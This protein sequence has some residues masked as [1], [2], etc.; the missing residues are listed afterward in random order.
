MKLIKPGRLVFMAVFFIALLVLYL[1]TLYRLQIVEGDAYYEQSTNSIQTTET[2]VAAR[3]NILDRY[4]RLLVYNRNC[5]NLLLDTDELFS[6]SNDEA[7]ASILSMCRIVTECGDTYYDTLPVTRTTPFEYTEM[8]QLQ[9]TRLDAFLE[10]AGLD[11]DASAVE[12]MAYMRTRYG[13]DN[14]YSAADMRTIAGI[15]YESN[16]RYIINT[17]DYVF[18]EDVSIE[19]ITALMESDVK[20]FTVQ[21]SYIREY[22]TSYAANILGYVGLM[23]ES[24]VDTYSELGYPLNAQVGKAGAELAFE[25]LLHGTDG[26]ATV[27]RTADGVVTGTVYT[28][29]PE[30]GNHVYLTIDIDMQAVAEQALAS[31]IEEKNATR[32]QK[33]LQLEAAGNTEDI[34]PLITGG[35]VAV[36]DVKTGEPLVLAS[37]PTYSLETLMED[38]SELLA[39]TN[40]PLFDRSVSGTY[41]PGSTFKPVTAIAAL[42]EGK[43]GV[44]TIITCTGQYT[45]YEDQGY[46]PYC[47]RRWGHGDLTVSGALTHS[48]NVVFFTLGDMLG[49]RAIDRYAEM[50]GLGVSTGIELSESIGYVA[51]PET[52]AAAYAGTSD[53]D[54]VAGD[55][56]QS[57]I[58]QSIT[59][60]TPLQLARYVAAIANRG[61][62]YNCSMLKSVSSY[63]YSDSLYE[64][65]V[66]VL[67]EV[68]LSDYI[69]DAVF[70]GM[71]GSANDPEGTAATIFNGYT[72]QV[73][74]KTG[75]AQTGSTLE[76]SAFVAFGPYDDPEIAICVI[77]EKGGDGYTV[78]P[79]VKAIFDY[80]FTFESSFQ[81]VESELTLL[82]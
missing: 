62:T 25:E 30:P 74:T 60:L 34:T 20:G 69:W 76:N 7:N 23:S 3:G 65:Q 2:V 47:W 4:G 22:R 46:A 70:E 8:S 37:Y 68:R 14:N 40:R 78:G 66:D 21:V 16:I 82:S 15:R 58:G 43:V 35:A 6:G 73:A 57:A 24:E 64:R 32:A 13:I 56:L 28:Q 72:P 59:N 26:T 41:E 75:T 71:W 29:A 79:I 77:V 31:F 27:T 42:G 38:Y 81:K 12:L 63:D 18:A 80:Y 36:V 50:F 52:K 49:I 19:T 61:T 10:N 33:N 55:N 17:S 44:D 54:W 9:R 53:A 5:N 45:A 67:T 39:D 51:S 11:A 48:C 1:V